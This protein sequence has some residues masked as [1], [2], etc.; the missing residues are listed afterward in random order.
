ML[1][2]QFLKV[3]IDHELIKEFTGFDLTTTLMLVIVPEL[4]YNYGSKSV[5]LRFTP[6]VGTN[7][8]WSQENKTTDTNLRL[9]ADFIIVEANNTQVTAFSAVMDVEA[10]LVF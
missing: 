6:I 2:T 10:D 7:V 8:D 9:Q 5:D 1:I 4:F 3:F